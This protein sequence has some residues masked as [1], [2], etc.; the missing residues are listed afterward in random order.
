[1]P[2]RILAPLSKA[3]TISPVGDQPDDDM[4][5][6]YFKNPVL[7]K[8]MEMTLGASKQEEIDPHSPRAGM[9]IL[10]A[11]AGVG[12]MIKGAQKIGQAWKA[13][14]EG[15]TPI[16]NDVYGLSEAPYDRRNFFYRASGAPKKAAILR[17]Q[18]SPGI[19]SDIASKFDDMKGKYD[20][21]GTLIKQPGGGIKQQGQV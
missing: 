6:R 20:I 11:L 14:D 5:D 13:A 17:R 18:A 21:L 15:I 10:G 1:M 4:I 2:D 8:I 7:N 3:E 19:I 9:A 12:G 16:M